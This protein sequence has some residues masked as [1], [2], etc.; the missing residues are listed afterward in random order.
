MEYLLE[1][2]CFDGGG[3]GF[4]LRRRELKRVVGAR[5]FAVEALKRAPRLVKP[6]GALCHQNLLR[7][8]PYLAPVKC[9]LQHSVASSKALACFSEGGASMRKCCVG[10]RRT[11]DCEE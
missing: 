5:G 9:P 7:L 6:C 4:K 2:G 11:N 8:E 10:T 1:E 3:A